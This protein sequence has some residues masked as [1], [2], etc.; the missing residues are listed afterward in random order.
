MRRRTCRWI[1][2]A[3]TSRT[4]GALTDRLTV[5][6]GLRYDLV[7]GFLIDQSKIPNYVALTGA[8]AAGRFDGVPGFE[9]FGK[10]AQEDKNNIQPRVGAV[11]DVHGDGTDVV[12]AGWGIY[13]DYGFT[14]ANILFPGLSA[15]GGSGVG[16]LG[17]Q[18]RRH[19]EPGWQLL[20]R[21][22]ADHEHR[23][24]E[25]SEP[26]RTVLQLERRGTAD[27]P[28][29]DRADVGWLVARARAVDGDRRR[30]RQ[31]ATDTI[32]ASAGR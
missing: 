6:A 27:S 10:K 31:H 18:H 21:R 17:E 20:H 12:R 3:S 4:T 5:N 29:V 15:Q 28:A 14:N 22:P 30:L 11:W 16:V 2:T 8:A 25:R 9:E 7:T 19:Q 24:P 13:Y 1:S 32:S 26:E 23:E